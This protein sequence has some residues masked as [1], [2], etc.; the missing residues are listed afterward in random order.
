[1]GFTPLP[2]S[3]PCLGIS[4][5]RKTFYAGMVRPKNEKHFM[6]AW[7]G[8]S[9]RAISKHLYTFSLLPKINGSNKDET[10]L[11]IF[12]DIKQSVFARSIINIKDRYHT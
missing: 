11:N 12:N 6:P 3:S 9:G 7:L 4:Q 5:E 8:S 2:S 10:E 1:M